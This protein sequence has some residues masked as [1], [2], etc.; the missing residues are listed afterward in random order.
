MAASYCVFISPNTSVREA[1]A[2]TVI[3]TG[4]GVEV[5]VVEPPLLLLVL[6]QAANNKHAMSMA[7]RVCTLRFIGYS[8]Y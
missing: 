1:A 4:A 6:P 7:K 2:K 8:P 5:G 3:F